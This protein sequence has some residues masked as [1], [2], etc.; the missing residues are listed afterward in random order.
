MLSV[1]MIGALLLASPVLAKPSPPAA[2]EFL[3]RCAAAAPKQPCSV[4]LTVDPATATKRLTDRNHIWWL[5]GDTLT[6]VARVG[7]QGWPMLCCAIQAPLE[8]LGPGGLAALS[9]R[10]PRME[11]ALID[12]A[13]LQGT[14]LEP[15]QA[16]RGPKAPP[17]PRQVEKLEGTVTRTKFKSDHL[18]EERGLFIYVPLGPPP[19]AGFPVIYMAD[20]GGL[21]LAKIAEASV[22]D[23]RSS[24]AMI[25]G[26][27]NA[28][29]PSSECTHSPCDRRM[30]EYTPTAS[31]QKLVAGSPFQRHLSFVTDEL[32]AFI[33]RT[34]PA[35]SNRNDRIV[36][37]Y[38]NGGVW[39]FS[40]AALRPAAFGKVLAMS[41]GNSSSI[42][43]S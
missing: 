9:V 25:V 22:G 14:M 19:P 3:P 10:V 28:V 2:E 18:G 13:V 23:G 40:A 7:D 16:I 43:R 21:E 11:E 35:S 12:V 29:G 37:G 17:A 36:A 38:S 32:M 4:A 34:Y 24:P 1:A 6:V 33:E 42:A 15:P 26:I 41:S 5:D 39:A 8:P 30:L 27:Q 31:P 20:G